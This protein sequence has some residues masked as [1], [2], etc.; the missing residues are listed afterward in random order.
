M[1]FG[2]RS[3]PAEWLHRMWRR[4]R[5]S[6]LTE[7]PL[8]AREVPLTPEQVAERRAQAERILKGGEAA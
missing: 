1:V 7:E 5:G 8:Q 3:E 6:A 4:R 2:D